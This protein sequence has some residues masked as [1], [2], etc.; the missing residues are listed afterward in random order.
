MSS[1]YYI[2]AND[3][4][5]MLDNGIYACQVYVTIAETDRF[6]NISDTSLVVLRGKLFY[7]WYSFIAGIQKLPGK[8]K[9]AKRI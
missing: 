6:M 3:T 2:N 1:M 7:W 4:N 9:Y 5:A 8:Q